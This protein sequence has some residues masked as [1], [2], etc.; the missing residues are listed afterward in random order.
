MSLSIRFRQWWLRFRCPTEFLCDNCRY[1]HPSACRHRVRPNAVTCP[2]TAP[3]NDVTIHKAK[4][5]SRSP[6]QTL[7]AASRR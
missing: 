6:K 4:S 3:K 7:S 1:D 2:T 5:L